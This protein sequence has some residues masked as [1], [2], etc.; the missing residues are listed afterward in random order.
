MKLGTKEFRNVEGKMFHIN[1]SES[2]IAK[3]VMLPGDPARCKI[4]A[5][6]FD[7]AQFVSSEREYTTY[8]GKKNGVGMTVMSTGMGCPS[9]A[10]GVEE[11]Y[12][13]GAKNL[14]RVGTGGALQAEI[15]PGAIVIPTGAVRGDGTTLEYVPA[16]YPAIA[17]IHVVT[18]LLESCREFGEEPYVG[19]VRSHDAFYVE[20][21]WA[22]KEW[23]ERIQ[24]W[25]DAGVKLLENES[26]ALFIIS[27]LL[28]MRAGSILLARGNL[29]EDTV[30]DFK[31]YFPQRV[32]LM[33]EIAIRALEKLDKLP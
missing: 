8:T 12:H 18:A 15:K 31:E 5:D 9:V 32:K 33:T 3:N 11:L 13:I 10:I 23:E 16:E 2:D 17:D 30:I 27:Q 21:P 20:S 26:S 19:V 4:I 24:K 22:H 1:L 25:V 14:I 28:G 7:E 29:V 6:F